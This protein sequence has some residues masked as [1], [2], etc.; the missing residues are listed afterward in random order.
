MSVS[1]F[2]GSRK[3]S[4]II[5]HTTRLRICTASLG[6]TPSTLLTAILGRKVYFMLSRDIKLLDRRRILPSN[7]VNLQSVLDIISHF[8]D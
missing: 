7:F 1:C 2:N 3:V 8:G 5:C 4:Q 6:W